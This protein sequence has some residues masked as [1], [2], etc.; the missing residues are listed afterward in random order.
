MRYESQTSLH[1]QWRA[2]TSSCSLGSLG[3]ALGVTFPSAGEGAEE[4]VAQI[5]I[6]GPAIQDSPHLIPSHAGSFVLLQ[7]GAQAGGTHR[8]LPGRE[9]RIKAAEVHDIL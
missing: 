2:T 8:L 9:E 6:L 5:S 4:W 3:W 7:A 1:R